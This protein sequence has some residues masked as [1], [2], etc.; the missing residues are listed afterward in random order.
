MTER[1]KMLRGE[2]YDPSDD[3]LV[4][5]RTRARKLAYDYNLS[6]EGEAERRRSLL[7]ALLGSHGDFY[8][9][10][11][12]VRFDYG[13][14]THVGDDFFSNFNFTV[15]DCAPVTIGKQCFIGPNVSIVT[16][17]HP[18]LACDRNM[19]RAPNGT[20]FDF[21]YARPVTIGDNVWLASNVTVCG[22]VTIGH[23]TV[24]GAGSVVTRDIPA[25]VFAAGNPCRVIRPLTEQDK[26]KLPTDEK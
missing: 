3:E 4:A 21:E 22:G 1:E 15:L 5:L 26:L 7:D 13:V 24:I 16:P 20:K 8:Y 17:V 18:M 2:L 11:P 10:E 25:G 6:Q 12:P 19:R 9:C 23:D 14:N